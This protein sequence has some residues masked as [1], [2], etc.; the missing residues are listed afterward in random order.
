MSDVKTKNVKIHPVLFS[1]AHVWEKTQMPDGSMKY[2]VSVIIPKDSPELPKIR[3]AIEQAGINK[4]GED[5][6]KWPKPFWNPLRDGD[7][8]RVEAAY[9]NCFY[10]S[11]KSDRTVGVVGPDAKPIMDH[12][13]FYSGVSGVVSVNFYGF[14]NSGKKGVGVG[15]NNVMKLKDGP[16]LD[17]KVAAE[18]EFSEFATEAPDTSDGFLGGG[19][20]EDAPF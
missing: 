1:F 12:D 19:S 2:S 20:G 6:T 16:R 4:F 15:L 13:E 18:D 9:K 14:D 11:P 5:K 10:L 3:A 17:G 8:E 7:E